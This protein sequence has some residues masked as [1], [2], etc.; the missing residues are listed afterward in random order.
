MRSTLRPNN[1]T[2]AV[3][4]T[5]AEAQQATELAISQHVRQMLPA[6]KVILE[7]MKTG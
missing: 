6:S 5:L 4:K 3:Q 7:R 1:Q 2:L